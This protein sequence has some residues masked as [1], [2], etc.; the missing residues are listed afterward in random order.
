MLKKKT[1]KFSKLI[2]ILAIALITI[3]SLLSLSLY[4]NNIRNKSNLL[5]KENNELLIEKKKT[6]KA[7][8]ARSEFYQ[9]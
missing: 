7:S 5:L 4:K 9:Q 1:N 2:N 8:K 6:E 3:L